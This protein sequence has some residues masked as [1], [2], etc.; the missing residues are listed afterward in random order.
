[1]ADSDESA[2]ERR[3]AALIVGETNRP[4]GTG[5]TTLALEST[6][7]SVKVRIS[8]GFPIDS[9]REDLQMHLRGALAAVPLDKPIELDLS[10]QVSA[11][12]VQPGVKALPGIRNILAVASGKGGVGKSTVTAN[13]ALALAQAGARVGVLDADIYGP[14][15]P[16]I[17]NLIGERPETVDGK[18]L[19]PLS[20]YGVSVMSI[21]FLVDEGQAV[22]WRGPM[23]TSALNQM[24]NQTEWGELDYL[25]VD[26]PPGTGDIQLTLAQKVPVSGAIIVTTP[27]DI[28]LSD[29]RKALDLFRKLSLPVL[30]VV[31]NMAIHV[32]SE[33]GHEEHIF[34]SD[35]GSVLADEY[36]LPLLG[37]LPLQR[38]VREQTDTGN[39][40]VIADPDG[41]AGRA[42][43][44]TALRIAGELA[45]T[46]RDYSH[47]FPKV[48]VEA[49]T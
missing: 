49:K 21:G 41:A 6:P 44:N 32:C 18:S 19:V 27:Q 26:L 8:Y 35:G 4:L 28:A 30:G 11:H 10:W 43:R 13:I 42:F 23:V 36:D 20:A 29:A 22:A 45:A 14:S 48:T 25:V 33:C 15:Q 38:I 16:R 3:L 7:A 17:L 5:G 34:G 46:G 37:S 24:L 9:I 40:T 47:L 12:A 1:M 39:P 2:L 31:E